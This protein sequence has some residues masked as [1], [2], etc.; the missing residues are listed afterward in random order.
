MV[1]FE[2]F[3]DEVVDREPD[4]AAPVRVAAEHPTVTLARDIADFVMLATVVESEGFLLVNPAKRTNAKTA[5]KLVFINEAFKTA[6][7]PP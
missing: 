4:R 5:E 2:R 1:P 6:P 7:E 3:D